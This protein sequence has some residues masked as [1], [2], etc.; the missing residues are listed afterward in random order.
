MADGSYI[1]NN[2]VPQIAPYTPMFPEEYYAQR[3]LEEQQEEPVGFWKMQ[4]EK[5]SPANNRISNE[6][7]NNIYDAWNAQI[8]AEEGVSLP[9]RQAEAEASFSP[10]EEILYAQGALGVA[11]AAGLSSVG[12]NA[13]TRATNQR[14][15]GLAGRELDL[16]ARRISDRSDAVGPLRTSAEMFSPVAAAATLATPL[17][18]GFR[19][20]PL[21]FQGSR[22]GRFLSPSSGFFGKSFEFVGNR[23]TPAYF[24][25]EAGEDEIPGQ[26]TRNLAPELSG[27]GAFMGTIGT[28]ELIKNVLGGRKKLLASAVK[29][30]S[31]AGAVGAGF[32]TMIGVGNAVDQTRV[33]QGREW[34]FR[35]Q[36][37]LDL[38]WAQNPEWFPE[39]RPQRR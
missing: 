8:A 26:T 3:A 24:M 2:Y 11:N 38:A 23:A 14:A 16:S 36:E 31:L 20:L 13:E 39:F 25:A 27:Y 15:I 37:N 32:G 35:N 30:L 9:R 1:G 6:D 34:A 33:E 28:G 29:P 17:G 7:M 19:S 5:L 12:R 18:A 21:A 10:W 4:W 22:L